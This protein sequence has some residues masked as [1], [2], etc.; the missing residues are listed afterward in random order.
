M[1]LQYRLHLVSKVH[2]KDLKAL[3]L[4]IK[5]ITLR[6]KVQYLV[7]RIPSLEVLINN[8]H[9]L[10]NKDP[11]LEI[12]AKHLEKDPLHRWSRTFNLKT[13]A[14]YSVTKAL[15]EAAPIQFSQT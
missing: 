11:C 6:I 14:L 1:P 15:S 4:V 10:L 13:K 12:R 9:L 7:I 3:L 8:K 2:R 5:G